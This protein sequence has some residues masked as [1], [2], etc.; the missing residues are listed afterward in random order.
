MSG[1]LDLRRLRLVGLDVSA[2]DAQLRADLPAPAGAV[3]LRIGGRGLDATLSVP[4]GA[5]VRFWQ[6]HGWQVEGD[7]GSGPVPLDRYDV[8]LEGRGGRCRVETR[9]TEVAAPRPRVLT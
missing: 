1:W 2:S 4:A 6:E 8:W 7:R 5:T 3:L 9:R